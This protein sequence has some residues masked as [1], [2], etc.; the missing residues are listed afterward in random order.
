MKK[1]LLFSFVVLVTSCSEFLNVK[2]TNV[3]ALANY[4]DVKALLGGHLR[5]YANPTSVNLKGT[6]VPYLE[7]DFWTY[8]HIISDDIDADTYPPSQFNFRILYKDSDNWQNE[9]M[10]GK[11]WSAYFLNIGFYNTIIDE[12]SRVEATKEDS[13]IVKCEVKV[14]R[15]WHIFKLMQYFSPYTNDILGLPLNLD[16]QAVGSYGGTRMTQTEVYKIIISDL[17]EVLNCETMPRA[18]YN[19]FFN[20]KIVNALLA[21][22]YHF[23]AGSGAGLSSDYDN[24]ISYAKIAM[25]GMSL[26]KTDS[27]THFPLMTG[28][29]GVTLDTPQAIYTDR[30]SGTVVQSIALTPKYNKYNFPSASL[31]RLYDANDIRKST[32]F[33]D[34]TNGIIK[35]VEMTP[36]DKDYYLYSTFSVAELHLIIAESYA[37]KNDNSNAKIWLD[38]FRINRIIGYLGYSGNDILTEILNERRKEFCFEYD[39]RWCDLVRLQTGWTKTAYDDKDNLTRTID[40][41]DYRFCMPIP[42][43]EEL[44]YNKI[45]QN[46]GWG[47]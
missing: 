18:T 47:I 23:K 22:I 15:A 2:P 41:K 37:R 3:L 25:E 36:S 43:L 11:I 6:T 5:M 16:A 7:T 38:S 9:Y 21:Q 35:F 27:Y 45:E 29:F 46:P 17:N 19:I 20:K 32:F 12:L 40:N 13:D 1:I 4:A 31:L 39:M 34:K 44:Q 8:F 42:A 33:E 14:L 10:P 26:Q 28:T 30:R 24:A